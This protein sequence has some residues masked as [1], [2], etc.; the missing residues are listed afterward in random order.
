[1]ILLYILI[2]YFIHL[3]LAKIRPIKKE[4]YKSYRLSVPITGKYRRTFNFPHQKHCHYS[5]HHKT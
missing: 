5:T 1:M 4:Y 3:I 2:I